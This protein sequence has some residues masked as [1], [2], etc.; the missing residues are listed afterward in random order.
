MMQ[1]RIMLR[2][3]EVKDFVARAGRCDFEIDICYNHY[4]VDAKSIVG[5]F[6]LDLRSIL[7]VTCHGFSTEFDQYLRALA[8]AV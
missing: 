8:I 3:E 5:V 2:P 1:Y 6:G 7:T 4:T